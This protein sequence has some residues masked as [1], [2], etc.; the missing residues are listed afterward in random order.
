MYVS[1]CIYTC[2]YMFVGMWIS[3]VMCK[4][5]YVC[6]CGMGV[7]VCI[8][9]HVY[10]CVYVCVCTPV[11]ARVCMQLMNLDICYYQTTWGC[12]APSPSPHPY[13]P[14]LLLPRLDHL[15]HCRIWGHTFVTTSGVRGPSSMGCGVGAGLKDRLSH[16]PVLCSL[17][18]QGWVFRKI[19]TIK[20]LMGNMR[21]ELSS[22]I[23]TSCQVN[24]IWPEEK[25][26]K[27]ST[28]ESPP[29]FQKVAIW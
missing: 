6:M 15:S 7:C 14:P 17:V 29:H 2:M 12:Q 8:H 21:R 16:F 1:V 13:F 4:C 25:G 18:T 27:G 11:Y 23:I 26:G 24:S 28:R 22:P 3:V 5:V 10:M 19:W 9:L 20:R